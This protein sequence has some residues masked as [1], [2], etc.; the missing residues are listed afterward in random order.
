[1]TAMSS[2][3]NSVAALNPAKTAERLKKRTRLRPTLAVVLGSG[4]G[5]AVT[6]LRVE[7]EVP[8][9]K[10]PGFLRPG[11][12]GHSGKVLFGHFE[13]TPVCVLSGRAHFYEGHSMEAVTFPIRLLA[14]FGVRDVLLTNAAGG[15]NRRFRPGDFMRLT[16]HINLMGTNPLRGPLASGR[17]RFIDMTRA[18]D[19][20]LG[21]LLEAAARKIKVRLRSG[22]YLAVAGPSYETPAE[23]RAF[24]RLGADAVGM[25][26]VLETIVARQCGLAVAG[27]SCITNLAAGRGN[28]LLSH[29]DVLAAGERVKSR[30]AALIEQFAKLY[31]VRD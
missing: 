15:I 5:H 22:V 24:A 14:E 29:A 8:Y 27:L 19:T 20:R 31:A 6:R 11:V 1:M 10:L 12:G 30:A 2:R 7:A 25:S 17:E 3:K 18:Y 13:D 28:A 16:D 4:F 21:R 9:G 23:I 26:T